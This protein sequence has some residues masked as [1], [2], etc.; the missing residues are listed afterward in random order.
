[1]LCYPIRQEVMANH[2]ATHLMNL[3]L[4]KVLGDH[5]EQKGSLVDAEKTRFDFSHDKPLTP[6]EIARI[7]RRVNEGILADLP[8]VAVVMPLAEAKK[9]PG[10]RAVFG[11]KYPDPVRVVMIGPKTPAEA[12]ADQSVEFCGGT[13]LTR[14]SQA[15]VFKIVSQE[16]AAKGIRRVTAITGLKAVEDYQKQAAWMAELEARFKCGP[17]DVLERVVALQEEVKKLQKQLAK[18]SATDLQGAAD[19]LFAAAADVGGVTVIVGEM[20]AGPDEAMR[21]QIDRLRE[22]AG[23]AVIVIGWAADA[24]KVGFLSMVTDDLK[25]KGPHAGNLVKEVS[26]VAGGKGGGKPT[27]LAQG[28]GKDPAKL[29]EALAKANELIRAAL[30]G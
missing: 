23:S 3:A 28:G 11:E 27:G 16:S 5:V 15:G 21:A 10:V 14:T 12:T 29:G 22:K 20:P 17:N 19:K 6:Q 2:T 25:A 30:G 8:V 18:G 24:D 9:I 7:E 26:A 1:M 13:H 4:K